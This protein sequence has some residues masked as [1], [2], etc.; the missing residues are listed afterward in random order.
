MITIFNRKNV[1]TGN[2]MGQFSNIR[3]T[4]ADHRIRYTYHIRNQ[5]GQWTGRGTLRGRTGSAG[6]LNTPQET[7]EVYVHKK[8]YEEAVH[9]IQ[10]SK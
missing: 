2:D 4:L 10:T 3:R 8:D 7:Y 9:L 6:Q 5:M 1:Y